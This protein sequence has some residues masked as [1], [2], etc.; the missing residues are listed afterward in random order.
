MFENAKSY[1]PRDNAVFKCAEIMQEVFEKKLIEVKQQIRA[2]HEQIVV[3]QQ[4]GASSSSMSS[5]RKRVQSESQR[6]VDSLDIDSDQLLPLDQHVL[7][8]FNF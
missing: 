2:R 8:L 6:T 1:N 3:D 4:Q 5:A 7:S